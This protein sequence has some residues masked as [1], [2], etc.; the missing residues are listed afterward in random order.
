[1]KITLSS[2]PKLVLN[3]VQPEDQPILF[4]L[5]DEVYRLGYRDFWSDQGDWYVNLIYNPETV[6]K[7]LSRS[8][9]HYFFVEWDEEKI[10][11]LKYDF[12]FSPREVEIPNAMK[13]HRLYLHPKAH[14]KG[15]ARLLMDHC[16]EIAKE[17][18]LDFIWLEAMEKK[19]QALRFYQKMGFEV[20]HS[21]TL[22]F[23]RIFPEFRDIHIL[24]KPI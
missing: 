3:P 1:M 17:S 2:T 15:I 18:K 6:Q 7:E 14:G 8:R 23:E 13:L 12:P 4:L 5:M 16:F 19:Q 11:V 9:S 21:Y 20:V 22:D 24:K 10:G